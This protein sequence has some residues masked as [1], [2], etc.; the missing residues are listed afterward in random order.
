M[1]HYEQILIPA[2]DV[3]SLPQ[4]SLVH[5]ANAL[6]EM[7]CGRVIL[8]NMQLNSVQIS[9]KE[10]VC[11]QC[12]YRLASISTTSIIRSPNADLQFGAPMD[13]MDVVQLAGP[14]QSPIARAYAKNDEVRSI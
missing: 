4:P 13:G 3:G 6:V 9:V 12:S 1:P 5:E 2:V 11:Q 7:D 14:Y 8:E 10:P